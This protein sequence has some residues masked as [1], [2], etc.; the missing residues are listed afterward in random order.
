TEYSIGYGLAGKIMQERRMRIV[1]DL[2]EEA[3]WVARKETPDRRSAIA[4]PLVAGE[5]IVGAMMLFHPEVNYFTDSHAR[6]VDA[7][8]RQVA[9]AINNAELYG[10][11]TDQAKRLG[12]MLRTQA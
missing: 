4:V 8:G 2:R 5:E 10:L 7:A 1:G 11:I 12:V 3:D 6:L 9:N